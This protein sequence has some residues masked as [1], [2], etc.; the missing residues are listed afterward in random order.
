MFMDRKTQFCR[1][2]S[3]SRLY[4]YINRNSNHFLCEYQKAILKF[5][6]GQKAQ[7]S[8]H[9]IEGEKGWRTDGTQLTMK[10]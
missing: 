5:M 3:S 7:N 9:S 6:W 2:T 4:L 8:Q 10:L 1:D